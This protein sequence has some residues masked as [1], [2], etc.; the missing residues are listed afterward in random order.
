VGDGT[1]DRANVT[2][3]DDL[4]IR[5]GFFLAAGSQA[6]C[7]NSEGHNGQ[8]TVSGKCHEN[9]EEEIASIKQ[10]AKIKQKTFEVSEGKPKALQIH[11]LG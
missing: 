2:N 9:S 10:V 8:R 4:G 3:F 1:T 6:E 5:C 7:C 11:P